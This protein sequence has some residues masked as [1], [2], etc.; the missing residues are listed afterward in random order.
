[1]NAT[2][3]DN[4]YLKH[5][6][7]MTAAEKAERRARIDANRSCHHQGR[8]ADIRAELARQHDVCAIIANV[9]TAR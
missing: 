5:S 8:F 9:C 3:P 4:D 7:L 2:L 6:S 1:M